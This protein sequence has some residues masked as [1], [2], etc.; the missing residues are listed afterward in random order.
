MGWGEVAWKG[1]IVCG[2]EEARKGYTVIVCDLDG[3]EWRNA[4]PACRKHNSPI[5]LYRVFISYEGNLGTT[6]HLVIAM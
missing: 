1:F 2:G 3:K 6:C 4:Y 5:P